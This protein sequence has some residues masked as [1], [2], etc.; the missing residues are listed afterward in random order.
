MPLNTKYSLQLLRRY[1]GAAAN[2]SADEPGVPTG[3]S[4][5]F[6]VGFRSQRHHTVT[7][8]ARFITDSAVSEQYPGDST[9]RC[10]IAKMTW[11]E[12]ETRNQW[13]ETRRDRV[14][15]PYCQIYGKAW[16]MK[17]SRYACL[18]LRADFAESRVEAF[19]RLPL[20]H[21]P[22]IFQFISQALHLLS[23]STWLRCRVLA[24]THIIQA[25]SHVVKARS[26][27]DNIVLPLCAVVG[28]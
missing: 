22:Y 6:P 7:D 1:V 11:R 5:L 14:Q 12:N 8:L 16:L 19:A 3:R 4:L 9:V 23:S 17:V 25:A 28:N 26:E 2:G 27:H 18:H 13:K 20:G 21:P 10:C 24:E 15:F